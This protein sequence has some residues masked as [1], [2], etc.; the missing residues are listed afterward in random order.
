MIGSAIRY[1]MYS[2]RRWR[3]VG[4]TLPTNALGQSVA[5]VAA[6]TSIDDDQAGQDQLQPSREG[7][8]G[9]DGWRWRLINA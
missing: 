1:V 3:G 4:Q 9:I 2:G 6:T 5:Y 7:D 8:R